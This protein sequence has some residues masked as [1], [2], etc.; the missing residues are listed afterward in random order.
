MHKDPEVR[1]REIKNLAAAF[2]QIADE[3]LP[4]LR[5]AKMLTS[6]EII[7]KSDEEVLAIAESNPDALNQAE[8][9]YAASLTQDLNKKLKIYH[10]FSRIFPKD[11]RGPNNEGS[12]FALQGKYDQAGPLFEKAEQLKADEPIIKNNLGTIALYK[13][14]LPLAE[15]YFGTASGSGNEVNY[16]L[17]LVNI[18]KGDYNK[19]NQFFRDYAD[20]NTALVKLLS[21]NYNGALYDLDKFEKPECYMKEY[22][23][24]IIGARTANEKLLFESLQNAVKYN[25]DMKSTAKND[26]EFAK[27]FERPEF[28]AIVQ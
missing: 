25:S 28:K 2:T 21:G 11:W 27:Y 9:L 7:G 1:E 19:A 16:N 10:S 17:A 13:N 23:K 6:I 26:L 20:P 4:K 12:V 8:L 15:E 5:R 24:A 22:L 3:I 14:N 18:K